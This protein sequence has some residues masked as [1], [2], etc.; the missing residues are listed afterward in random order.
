M[1]ELRPVLIIIAGSCGAAL[2][3]GLGVFLW[4]STKVL[5][6]VE[7]FVLPHFEPPTEAEIRGGVRDLTV[8]ARL[9]R[10]EEYQEH[11]ETEASANGRSSVW[12]PKDGG[13]K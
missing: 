9:G 2:L 5:Q 4:R 11:R 8:P 12:T 10:L 3:T 7:R 6:A 1:S 13:S